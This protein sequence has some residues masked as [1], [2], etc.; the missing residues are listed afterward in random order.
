MAGEL[1][2]FIDCAEC[3]ANAPV[4]LNKNKKLFYVCPS[5]GLIYPN[6]KEG[7]DKLRA[8]MR[9]INA[10][11]PEPSH[12]SVEPKAEPEKGSVEPTAPLVVDPPTMDPPKP[13]KPSVLDLMP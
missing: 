11:E 12:P 2:G 4:R 10:P 5:C 13:K 9:P 6:M 3:K 8:R 7:Q 1:Q